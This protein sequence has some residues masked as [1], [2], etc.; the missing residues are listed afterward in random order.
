MHI[1]LHNLLSKHK[2][3]YFDAHDSSVPPYF[4]EWLQI[5]EIAF[6]LINLIWC[7]ILDLKAQALFALLDTGQYVIK[8]TLYILTYPCVK[9]ITKWSFMVNVNL[10]SICLASKCTAFYFDGF[11]TITCRE[12]RHKFYRE[13]SSR[14][15]LCS[16]AKQETCAARDWKV[17]LAERFAAQCGCFNRQQFVKCLLHQLYVSA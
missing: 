5:E 4:T 16:V 10:M 2:I 12:S 3:L 9:T 15:L 14:L 8:I 7:L 1:L 6:T 17:N 11:H 13:M